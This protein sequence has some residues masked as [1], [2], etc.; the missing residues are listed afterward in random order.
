MWTVTQMKD[1]AL[2][3]VVLPT[4]FY[5][6]ERKSLLLAVDKPQLVV[7]P[8]T[9]TRLCT[10]YKNTLKRQGNQKLGFMNVYAMAFKC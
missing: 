1:F 3:V 8:K 2:F 4:F 6:L 5:S 7:F 10:S 9:V